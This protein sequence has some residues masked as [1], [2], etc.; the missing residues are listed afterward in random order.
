MVV[1]DRTR[2]N[3]AIYGEENGRLWFAYTMSIYDGRFT[4][5]FSVNDRIV[6]YTLTKIYDRNTGTCN[7]IKY[8]RIR[9]YTIVYGVREAQPGYG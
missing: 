1:N 3:T 7:M 8:G 5:C 2:R 9:P 6:S 4:P